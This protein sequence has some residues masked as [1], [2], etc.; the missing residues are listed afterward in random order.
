MTCQRSSRRAA[1]SGEDSGG[2]S[3]VTAR[4]VSTIAELEGVD[5]VALDSPLYE[6]VDPDALEALVQD[7][8]EASVTV[9]F[10]YAGYRVTVVSEDELSVEATPLA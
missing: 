7:G 3:T 8:S 4:I 6:A 5:P 1:S 9:G 2:D 10:D